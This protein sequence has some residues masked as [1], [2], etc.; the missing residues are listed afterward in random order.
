MYFSNLRKIRYSYI[1]LY[2]KNTFRASITDVHQT[3]LFF[4]GDAWKAKHVFGGS[5]GYRVRDAEELG[6]DGGGLF[7]GRYC[8]CDGHGSYREVEPVQVGTDI[9]CSNLNLVNS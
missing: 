6:N 9:F 5:R 2:I 4:T 7:G 3:A 8:S 1:F